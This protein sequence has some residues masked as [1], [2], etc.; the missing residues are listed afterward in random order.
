MQNKP[1]LKIKSN[2]IKLHVINYCKS[3]NYYQIITPVPT[4]MTPI[5]H[6]KVIYSLC[7]KSETNSNSNQLKL[8]GKRASMT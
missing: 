3:L 7:S 2:L 1:L 8:K 5:Y 6:P 4:P